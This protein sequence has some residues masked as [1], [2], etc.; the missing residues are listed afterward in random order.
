MKT[1]RGV[2]G[3]SILFAV[4]FLAAAM[5]LWAQSDAARLQ[6]L[7]NDPSGAVVPGAQVKVTEVA[8]NRALEVQTDEGGSYSF[9]ALPP[10]DYR[11][12]ISLAGFQT[13]TQKV[14][15]QVAQVANVNFTLQPGQVSEEVTVSA[16]AAIV[17]SV[18]SDMGLTVQ[19]KQIEDLPLNGR[20]FTELATLIPG[21]NRGVPGNNATGEGNNAE[22][23]RYS[24]SGGAALDVNGARPQANNF[25]LDGLDNNESLV[26]T[27]VF[28]PPADAIQEFRVQTNM[29]PAEFGRAGGGIVNTTI[30]SGTNEFHGDAF[31]YLR[32]AYLDARPTFAPTKTAFRRNQF[33][34]TLGGPI[35][36]NRIFVFGDYQGLR[37]SEPYEQ[38]YA[39]VPTSLMRQG[40]FS[41]LLPEGITIHDPV[42]GVNFPGNVIPGD[43]QNPVGLKYLGAYPLPNVAGRIEQNYYTSRQQVQNF[44]DYDI[45]GDWLASERD[46]VFMRFS[47]AHDPEV[48]GSRF[49]ALPAGFGSG[50]QFT[51]ADGAGRGLH[52][53]VQPNHAQ[54]SADRLSTHVPRLRPAVPE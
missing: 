14:T 39:S 15:L 11:I 51:Y 24:N 17:D 34:G 46:Q 43:L 5:S 28:F 50:S 54:R 3:R 26:N 4:L 33:G 7:V 40:N 20:N 6:G 37:Q 8:T 27:I 12:T 49:P 25:M 10:G 21:V 19:T 47:Y 16:S 38:Y 41:E 42:T 2:W 29:A 31:D 53:H 30:K 36:K 18:T 1:P 23:F 52:S 45:R 35:K 44:D 48:T 32:N 22:T 9:P 13:T